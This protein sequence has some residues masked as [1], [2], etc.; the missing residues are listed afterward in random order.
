M[1]QQLPEAFVEGMR[2]LLGE[3][4][5]AFMASYDAPRLYGLRSNSLKIDPKQWRELSP[6]QLRPIPWCETGSYYDGDDRPGK[7]PYYHAGLYYIQEP[8]AMAPVELLD[9]QPGHRVLDLC[10][11]PGGK[12]T[13]IAAKLQGSGVLVTNDNAGERTKALAKNVEL[14]GVRNAVVLNEEP[15]SLAPVFAG[16]FDRILVDAPCSGEGMF[17]KD[18]SMIAAW[19]RHSVER[20]AGM[21]RDIVRHAAKMLAPGGILVYSTCTFS[22]AENEVQIAALLAGEPEL[23][24]V[25]IQ[26]APGFVEGRLDWGQ[27]GEV[28]SEGDAPEGNSQDDQPAQTEADASGEKHVGQAGTDA[29]DRVAESGMARLWPHLLDGEG[30][31][32][33]VVRRKPR[34][35]DGQADMDAAAEA[36]AVSR[37]SETLA[38]SEQSA[39]RGKR[40]RLERRDE[41][42]SGRGDRSPRGGGSGKG[43]PG[44]HAAKGGKAGGVAATVVDSAEAWRSFAEEHLIGADEWAGRL[45]A[46]GSRVYWQP[47]GLP[48]LDG[49][50]V[51]RAG[52]YLGDAGPHRFEPS[53]ALALGLR[54]SEIK[55]SWSAGADDAAIVRFLKGETLHL[56]PEELTITGDDTPLKGYTLI[57][58]DGYPIGWGKYASGMLKN[59]LPAGWRWV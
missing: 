46:F 43:A 11:A 23:E 29:G 30:H 21:Q 47:E 14:A 58:V 55:R 36:A 33:A 20:C 19:E 6:F 3:Q 9:V 45:V 44:K 59:E 4:F 27:A 42:R 12:S 32:V 57:C 25:T 35:I 50:R 2:T 5:D 39:S 8:S 24:R 38:A 17:R 48:L 22:P 52:W 31:F 54:R 53:Q 40:D 1:K 49:L 16:W 18:E 7:H 56:A 26:L 10:A 15:S 41:G 13:Q 51:V 28:G 34:T 37:R